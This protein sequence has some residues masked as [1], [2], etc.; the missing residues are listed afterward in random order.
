[1]CGIVGIIGKNVVKVDQEHKARLERGLEAVARRGPDGR[2]VWNDERTILGHTRL[3]IIDLDARSNQPM[4]SNNWVLVYNGEIYNF[5]SLRQELRGLGRDF[6][7]LSDTEVLLMSIEEWGVEK[8]LTKIAGMFAFIAY[9]KRTGVSYL[10]R[11]HLG[12]KPLI[13][14]QD[15]HGVIYV[16]SSVA[17]ILA[18]RDDVTFE[19]NNSA[20][21]SYFSLGGTTTL[22]SCFSDINRLDA[23]HFIVADPQGNIEIKRYWEPQYQSNFSM[24]DLA[25]IVTEYEVADVRSAL[26]LSGGVDSSYLATIFKKLDCFHLVSPEEKFAR[27]VADKFELDFVLV[28]PEFENYQID[29]AEAVKFHGEPL[30]SIGV[31]LAVSKEIKKHGYKMAI[32]AN[33]AD[34]LFLGYSR[35]PVPEYNLEYMPFYEPKFYRFFG[36]QLSHIFRDSRHYDISCLHEQ[37]CS[38]RQLGIDILSRY[39]LPG[40]PPSANYRWLELMTYVL[41]DLNPTLDAASMYHSVEV[42]VPFLDHR[43]VQGVLS[44][45]GQKLLS[46]T[47]GRKAP[48]KSHLSK[49]FPDPLFSRTKLGFSIHSEHLSNIAQ[50]SEIYL[51]KYIENKFLSLK[52]NRSS[53]NYG[54][55]LIYLGNSLFGF[56]KWVGHDAAMALAS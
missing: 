1:M 13:Y 53:S 4:E 48:L 20:L 41:C 16:A 43:I 17:A 14:S 50:L 8:A 26:F 6:S 56:S 25:E 42:R 54:R 29:V 37:I 44:W 39:Q 51:D 3:A 21:A 24:D 22:S 28:E 12:I 36:Q 32:S 11:D 34:E 31:P 45:E 33:G 46:P 15:E 19:I 18:M 30:M 40:F 23:A 49:Y 7:T 38:L 27:A 10:A 55:D 9:D 47:I 2:G 52:K 35:T 5:Q